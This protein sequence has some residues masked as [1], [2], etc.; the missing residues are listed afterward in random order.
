MI[1]LNTYTE[2]KK[3]PV[4]ITPPGMQLVGPN[5]TRVDGLRARVK[6]L[7]MM[8]QIEKQHKNGGLDHV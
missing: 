2:D 3:Q 5:P 4:S 6:A 1:W 7:I 8:L